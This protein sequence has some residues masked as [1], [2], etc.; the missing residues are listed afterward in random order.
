MKGH[1]GW[2]ASG[3]PMGSAGSCICRFGLTSGYVIKGPVDGLSGEHC[4]CECFGLV[5]VWDSVML[6]FGAVWVV[7]FCFLIIL[8]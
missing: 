6:E 5:L 2:T 4:P 7:L 1:I 8:I 3:W